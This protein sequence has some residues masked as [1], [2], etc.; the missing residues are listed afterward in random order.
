MNFT[1][2]QF[3]ALAP[4]EPKFTTLVRSHYVSYVGFQNA[5]RID[6]ILK[7]A[8]LQPAA[9]RTNYACAD[10]V[11][12]LVLKAATAWFQD[13]D[14]RIAAANDKQAVQATAEAASAPST[15]KADPTPAK[16]K[17]AAKSAQSAAKPA[18]QASPKSK[19]AKK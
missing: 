4:F 11:K 3:D 9:A 6:A 1:N 18:K 14:A 19:T 10:C 7:E 15:P 8:G 13:R 17:K 2:E 16:T 12:R 5:R